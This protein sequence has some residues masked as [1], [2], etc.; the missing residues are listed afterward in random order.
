MKDE[1]T[2]VWFMILL[3]MLALSLVPNLYY[4]FKSKD[5]FYSDYRNT[6]DI[7]R[8]DFERRYKRNRIIWAVVPFLILIL[9]A[10]VNF[11]R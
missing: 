6:I 1:E 5:D 3:C 7:G 2:F 11:F 9:M 4:I 8:K 10:I